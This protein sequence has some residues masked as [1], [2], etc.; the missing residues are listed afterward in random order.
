M[1][2]YNWRTARPPVEYKLCAYR[3][4]GEMA[5][6][7]YASPQFIDTLETSTPISD[8]VAVDFELRGCPVNKEQLVEVILAFLHR[9]KLT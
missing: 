1:S 6:A 3:D 8:H 9:R 2:G 5:S 4:V 7:V